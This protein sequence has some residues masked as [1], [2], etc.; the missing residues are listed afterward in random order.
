MM[1]MK[2]YCKPKQVN[3]ESVSFNRP[4]VHEAFGNGKL[5]RMDF[6]LF[7]NDTGKITLEELDMERRNHECNKILAAIDVVAE[8][9]TE[10][11]VKRDLNLKPVRQFKRID[12]I[13]M[14]ERDLCQESPEQQVFEY[15]LVRALAPLF[16]AKILPCQYGSIPGRGQVSGARKIERIIRRKI[17]GTADAVKG[18]VHHAYPSTTTE[19]VMR[20]LERDIHKNKPLLWLA[21]AVMANYPG[22]VL[23]IGGYFSTWA[24]NYVM[25]YLLRYLLSIEQV[26]RGI[27]TRLVRELVCY[28]DDFALVGRT[29]QLIKAMKKVTRWAKN[30]LGLEI[31]RVWQI[32]H[33]ASIEEEK[34]VKILRQEYGAKIRTPALDMMG[35][36][37]RRTYT[38]IRKGVFRRIR[39]QL[40]RAARDLALRGYIPHWRAAKLTAYNGWITNSDSKRVINE[41]EVNKI[42]TA[43]RWSVARHAMIQNM[44]AQAA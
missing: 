37:V 4:A 11:I 35:Y 13:R 39:R 29:S 7:L 27:R 5:R 42:M 33:F 16:H 36:A 12:G 22:A 1:I 3:I 38:I 19:C 24:Y 20:L 18:D 25:S 17:L 8:H 32:V 23:L 34:R 28:A 31:K 44:E 14:K 26:R 6:R 41:Y 2:T 43:A 40:L 9:S 30:T 21:R 10:K 15:I